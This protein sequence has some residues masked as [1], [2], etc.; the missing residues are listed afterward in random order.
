[1]VHDGEEI[2]NV[3]RFEESI[4]DALVGIV[5]ADKGVQTAVE[6]P[7]VV[8]EAWGGDLHLWGDGRV[9]GEGTHVYLHVFERSA[10]NTTT[11]AASWDGD[12]PAR[13]GLLAGGI[14]AVAREGAFATIEEGAVGEVVFPL[15]PVPV[16]GCVS[17]HGVW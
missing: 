5:T 8:V 11:A 2:D 15:W 14:L 6:A 1:M 17:L 3:V 16:S 7:W 9:P 4:D 13:Y 12:R 10:A